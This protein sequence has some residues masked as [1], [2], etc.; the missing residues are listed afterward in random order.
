MYV[1]EHQLENSSPLI[2]ISNAPILLANMIVYFL[3]AKF[4][5]PSGVEEFIQ[6][7]AANI[8]CIGNKVT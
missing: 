3:D 2:R 5:K 1:E 7:A 4:G 8:K 6:F